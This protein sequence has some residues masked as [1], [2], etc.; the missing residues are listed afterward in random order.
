MPTT[1]ARR[2]EAGVTSVELSV[3]M[4][5]SALMALAVV[6]VV[7]SALGDS[8]ARVA[9]EQVVATF[10]MARQNAV[11]SGATY[12]VTLGLETLHIACVSGNPAGNVCP[13]QRPPD[14]SQSLIPGPHVT[15][16]VNPFNFSPTGAASAGTVQVSQPD[17]A[18]WA[19]S[20]SAAGRVRSCSPV[21]P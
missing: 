18:S 20:L 16:S 2:R 17:A 21:C 4:A 10:R 6:P 11:S 9:A 3:A 14:T 7:G 19:V 13:T 1:R 12:Q 8:K 15:P 5:L